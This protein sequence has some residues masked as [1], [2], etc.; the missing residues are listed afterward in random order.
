M[1]KILPPTIQAGAT[2]D[3]CAALGNFPA[4]EWTLAVHLRG[5]AVINLAATPDGAAHK[6]AKAAADTAA[7][8]PGVYQYVARVTRAADGWVEQVDAGQ[9]EVLRDLAT[10]TDATDL[11]SDA[12]RGLDAIEAVLQK[13][14]GMDQMRYTINGREL[15]RTPIADLLK[16]KGHYQTLVRRERAKARGTS[17]WR[18]AAKVRL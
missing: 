9:V 16:L 10:I 8:T 6:L 15:W 14:A 2:L 18:P 11:R 4:P 17:L 5:P 3:T 13:R 12:Q 7:F 1:N